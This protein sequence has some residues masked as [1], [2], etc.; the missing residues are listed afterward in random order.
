MVAVVA[1][2]LI[3]TR[4]PGALDP[5]QA[6]M[7]VLGLGGLLLSVLALVLIGRRLGRAA[8]ALALL[9]ALGVACLMTW[10]WIT[11]WISYAA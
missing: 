8:L 3:R 9:L 1:A 7:I 10:V 5:F 4:F 6:G 11:V 2:L